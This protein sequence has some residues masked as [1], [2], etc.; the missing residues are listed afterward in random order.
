LTKSYAV[1]SG[2]SLAQPDSE[3]RTALP[4]I[5]SELEPSRAR[6]DARRDGMCAQTP[7]F[8]GKNNSIF[9]AGPDRAQL[10]GAEK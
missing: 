10:I 7:R 9:A 2:A 1:A 3:A 6:F 8:F 4:F 5:H